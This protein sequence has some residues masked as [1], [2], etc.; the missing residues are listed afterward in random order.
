[1]HETPDIEVEADRYEEEQAVLADLAREDQIPSPGF[2][3]GDRVVEIATGCAGRVM[4]VVRGEAVS[5]GVVLD[6]VGYV[7]RLEGS[8]K[9]EVDFNSCDALR[10]IDGVMG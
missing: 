6:D 4:N 9:A 2:K 7:V 1:M 10:I 5:Y 8:L 3:G